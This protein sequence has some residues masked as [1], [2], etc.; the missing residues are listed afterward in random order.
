MARLVV[1]GGAADKSL[2]SNA[3]TLSRLSLSLTT[4]FDD[5]AS[6]AQRTLQAKSTNTIDS[7]AVNAQ[8]PLHAKDETYTLQI[9]SDGSA[10]SITANTTLGLFRGLTTFTQFWYTFETT[11]YMVAAPVSITD[12]PAY[13]SET[14]NIPYLPGL[15]V[16]FGIALALSRFDAR[17]GAKFVSLIR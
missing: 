12:K 13:V 9:P 11:I 3:T 8:L 2:I 5:S 4:S 16:T 6:T 14:V 7:I 10:A 17:H 1:G 15:T